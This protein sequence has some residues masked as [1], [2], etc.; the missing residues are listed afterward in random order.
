MSVMPERWALGRCTS[1]PVSLL[2][3]VAAENGRHTFSAGKPELTKAAKDTRLANDYW[4]FDKTSGFAKRELI[5]GKK[6]GRARTAHLS[7]F[8]RELAETRLK[9]GGFSPPRDQE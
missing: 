7:T 4:T 3:D 8:L 1:L 2:A 5:S 6:A 9:T